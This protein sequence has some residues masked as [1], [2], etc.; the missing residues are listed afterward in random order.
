[1]RNK[2]TILIIIIL[3]IFIRNPL[4]AKKSHEL[5]F[6]KSIYQTALPT[7]FSNDINSDIE[8][9]QE[10]IKAKKQLSLSYLLHLTYF[11]LIIFLLSIILFQYRKRII[12]KGKYNDR[13][14]SIQTAFLRIKELN[15]IL[16]NKV[17]SRTEEVI[18]H[19]NEQDNI[20]I[21]LSQSQKR[22]E[23]IFTKNSDALIIVDFDTLAI[24]DINQSAI[25]F[26]KLTLPNK[27]PF[28]FAEIKSENSQFLL[29]K[30]AAIVK[31]DQEVV[32]FVVGQKFS[33][34][35]QKWFS[36][37]SQIIKYDEKKYYFISI[38]N[39]TKR[40]KAEISIIENENRLKLLTEN[41]NDM[42][43]L[44]DE[45]LQITYVS[46][47][48]QSNLGYSP[49][50]VI[51]RS[52]ANL[53]LHSSFIKT[54]DLINDNF[55]TPSMK[56]IL[57]IE[58]EFINKKG[59]VHVEEFKT[60]FIRNSS[61]R[62]LIYAVSRDISENKKIE[63]ELRESE[64]LYRLITNNVTDVIF[65][66]DTLLNLK[67]VNNAIAS[68][69][70]YTPS[71]LL[72]MPLTS[73]VSEK[74]QERLNEELTVFFNNI[75]EVKNF[76]KKSIFD[77]VL[78]FIA[79]DG[80][81]KWGKIQL[82]LL[83]DEK[84]YIY[85]LV[86]TIEDNT[87]KHQIALFEESSNNFFKKLFYDSPV[88]MAII[89]KTGVVTNI[90]NAF[91]E[92]TGYSFSS[93]NNTL[94]ADFFVDKSDFDL[95]GNAPLNSIISQLKT[96]NNNLL[97][98][99]YDFE[100]ISI[101]NES[102]KILIVMRD[103]TAEM[104]A[105]ESA[106]IQQ[107][108]F[109]ALSENSPDIIARF[110]SNIEC[111]Y[112]NPTVEKELN[113]S[114]DN[115]ISKKLNDIGLDLEEISF[116]SD[117]FIQVFLNGNEKVVDFSLTI[118][119]Q[120]KHFQCRVIP[121]FNQSNTVQSIMVVTRNM[122]EYAK[123]IMMLHENVNQT[124]LLNKA[125]MFCNQSKTKDE[126][127]H[128][129]LP[130]LINVFGFDGGG[131]YEYNEAKKTAILK[132]DIGLNNF[133]VTNNSIIN[134]S[135]PLFEDVYNLGKSRILMSNSP[136][137]I[138]D[139]WFTDFEINTAYIT[140]IFSNNKIIGSINLKSKNSIE[141]SSLLKE[142]IRIISQEFGSS[143][144]RIEAVSLKIESEENY[145]S[146]V[147]TTTDLVWKVNEFLVYTFV[148]DKCMDLLG[149]TSS[150]MLGN[151]LI[152]SISPEEKLKI[153]KF[154]DLNKTLLEKFTLVDVPLMKK[155][156]KIV[157]V[158][159]NGYPLTD[160]HGRFIGY[161]GINRDISIRKINEDLRQRKEI[162]ERMAQVKQEFVSNISHELRTPLTAI[163]GHTE[164]INS[165][166]NDI[167]ISSHIRTIE[168][169]SK[170]LL[171]LINDILD[172]SKI[173]AG[174]LILQKDPLN[175]Y[176]FFDDINLTF[177]PLCKS[178]GIHFYLEID[179]TEI[180]SIMV[181]EL[182]LR[183]IVYNVVANAIKFTNKGYVKLVV[184]ILNYNLTEQTI[185]IIIN[186]IDTGIGVDE[187]LTNNIFD[188]YTQAFG[189]NNKKYGGSG[190]GLS[191]CKNLIELMD[192]SISFESIKNTGSN[193][194]I[195]IPSI[196]VTNQ[197][198]KNDF[199]NPLIVDKKIVV[200]EKSQTLSNSIYRILDQNQC[201]V[202]S[203]NPKDLSIFSSAA[204]DFYLIDYADTLEEFESISHLLSSVATKTVVF[205]EEEKSNHFFENSLILPIDFQKINDMLT[206]ILSRQ[207]SEDENVN[208]TNIEVE[209]TS[210]SPETKQKII[211]SL[212]QSCSPIWSKASSNNSIDQIT[213]LEKEI[214]RIAKKNNIRF[215]K[216]YAAEIN[217]GLKT[218]DIEK[219]KLLLE[220]YPKI[221]SYINKH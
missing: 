70:G 202:I 9:N 172:V 95:K 28:H 170:S 58:L 73:Y 132:F 94:F 18:D 42:I 201:E 156:G 103:I 111:V 57:T 145:R 136:A 2:S 180:G 66:S 206:Q 175:I 131:I 210:W 121:E 75:S 99:I 80:S 26:F 182:R 114:P 155:S 74:G 115:F 146:L 14:N 122:T 22:F 25:D 113:I 157:H 47:S 76:E 191:I 8:N 44:L 110:N 82:N 192:G 1:M 149:F 147:E 104:K 174:K 153:R 118:K 105:K 169:N 20:L 31:Q 92:K 167:E 160:S 83:V 10:S 97:D 152:S 207:Y 162:A 184:N 199:Y 161:A 98:I 37:T 33:Q 151:S 127:Y 91:I 40:K 119:D 187:A 17:K 205:F 32:D 67:F 178:K 89:S 106:I 185:D 56:S 159:I 43:W 204:I 30:I 24:N 166:T 212:I 216:Q 50:E 96:A 52:I 164:I 102:E 190:L 217:M 85:G 120:K 41:I 141:I 12:V 189:Q 196:K 3:L 51:N 81:I 144:D 88:M 186:V 218:F 117:H 29:L 5:F 168:S 220:I 188:S 126:L 198:A 109:K 7:S 15:K 11:L 34:N 68:F 116:L 128:N 140:P 16:E 150:E 123:A 137:D 138:K 139:L 59:E 154:L 135:H 129:I 130:L 163:M 108:Q 19:I 13:I 63:T 100:S 53:L 61:N 171:R 165:K 71:E 125:I 112:I 84:S 197:K 65:T 148:N 90:N 176:K 36:V 48:I 27:R 55:S 183:Q 62:L 6:L 35:Y 4:H 203:V 39:I 38:S 177:S 134:D 79:K 78:D 54:R 143:I 86:G 211:D 64:Q 124:K 49:D 173:E 46:P 209:I 195:I 214:F 158:E 93:I 87:Q 219:L 60:Q 179:K 221:I 142:T 200:I 194:R 181:D 101:A 77:D 69:L 215:M 133:F 107:E 72:T 23:Q 208:F 45:Q 21:Q 193:F 213:L